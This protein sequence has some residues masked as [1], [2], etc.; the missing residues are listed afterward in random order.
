MRASKK[1]VWAVT[2][3]VLSVCAMV[4]VTSGCKPSQGK[5]ERQALQAE[6]LRQEVETHLAEILELQAQGQADAA[7][8]Q[9][10][11]GLAN[12]KYKAYWHRFFSQKV[13]L[14]LV[15]DKSEEA[16]ALILK[17][18]EKEP[19]LAQSVF[20]RIR[21]YHQ[22]K[23][24]HA[25]VLT[26][27]KSLLGMGRGA[28]LPQGLRPQVLEWQL[29]A[30][31]SLDTSAGVAEA[32]SQLLAELRPERAVPLLQQAI[33]TMLT[34]EKFAHISE[35]LACLVSHQEGTAQEYKDL[36]A[37]SHLKS[38]LAQKDWQNVPGAVE[39]CASQLNDSVLSALLRQTFLTLQRTQQVELLE[40][41]S[42]SVFLIAPDKEVSAGYAARIWVDIGMLT[43]KHILQERLIALLDAKVQAEQVARVFERYFYEFVEDRETIKSLCVI[44]ERI[45][46]ACTE[47]DVKNSMKVK[48][49]DGAFIVEDYDLVLTMLERGIPEKPKEWHDMSIPK[50][51]AH[52]ALIQDNT[53]EAIAYFREFMKIMAD[54]GP[55]EEHDP[56]T[57][58]AYSKEW[59]LGR[60]AHRIAT[61]YDALSDAP[62]AA[63]AREEAKTLFAA[64]LAKA[65]KDTDTLSVL[66][67]EMKEMGF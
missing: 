36:A 23:R 21:A 33:N 16:R 30:A 45:T 27:C 20:G 41:I 59:I 38:L 6:A 40:K 9:L 37:V 63:T 31:T 56:T 54:V 49:L 57:G 28:A 12:K 17:T 39:I 2:L 8:R 44:G 48:L 32:V 42:H 3:G 34:A 11:K 47:E 35:V 60:N 29:S 24:D 15:Q 7:L 25:A 58:V 10:D 61:L 64:A 66:K 67:E 53:Q 26:W 4:G 55:D 50:V 18:W 46:D 51:K 1:C 13:D 22:G 14:L 5:A 43:N 62:N 65:E 19:Q 52:R